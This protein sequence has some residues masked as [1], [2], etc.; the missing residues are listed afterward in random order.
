MNRKL[1]FVLGSFLLF[2]LLCVRFSSVEVKASNGYPVHNLDTGLDYATI[3]A[4]VDAAETL[5]GHTVRVDAGI[6][7]ESV[8]IDKPVFLLG[9]NISTTIID[10]NGMGNCVLIR[11]SDVKINGFTIQKSGNLPYGN[12]GILLENVSNCTMSNNKVEEC[13]YGVWLRN[14]GGNSLKRNTIKDN[15]YNFRVSGRFL[16]HF[17]NEVDSSNIV[18]GKPMYY[19]VNKHDEQVPSDAGYVAVVN[20]TNIMVR[21]I[22]LNHNGQGILFAFAHDSTI[23][24]VSATNN[25]DGIWIADSENCTVTAS[26]ANHNGHYGIELARSTNCKV[27]GNNASSN[28]YE[29]TYTGYG[30]RLGNCRNVSI[31]GNKGEENYYAIVVQFSEDC[32][33]STNNVSFNNGM[34][35]WPKFCEK[36]KIVGNSVCNNGFYGIEP[37]DSNHCIVS[38]NNVS[39]NGLFGIWLLGAIGTCNNLTVRGNHVEKNKIGIGLTNSSFNIIYHNNFVNNQNQMTIKNSN[40]STFVL[41]GEGNYWSD[42]DG[43]DANYDGIGDTAYMIDDNNTD[44]YPLMGVFSSFNTS[45]NSHVDVISNSTIT[46]FEYFKIN[47]TINMHVSNRS[48]IQSHGFCRVSIHKSLISPPYTVVIDDGLTEVLYFNDTLHD[49]DTHRWIYFAYPHSAREVNIIPEFPTVLISSLFI[50]TTFLAALVYKR[51][52]LS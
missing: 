3:Q 33:I 31:V 28:G 27:V 11:S 48:M 6:Y 1:L 50:M 16:S 19:W 42:Y 30:I 45:S 41:D 26:D 43:L 46:N 18:N 51:K 2:T 37:E 12:T 15:L 44:N 22:N 23:K 4:A 29:F 32:L 39:N 34:G 13:G 20:S 8:V 49:N 40:G 10:A 17:I 5:G 24:N 52:H 14:S 9:E 36:C 35:I 38:G 21:N 47:S 25:Y 7:Y